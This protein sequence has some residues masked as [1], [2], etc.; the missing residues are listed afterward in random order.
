HARCG[1]RTAGRRP[2]VLSAR[3]RYSRS[4][5]AQHPRARV[6]RRHPRPHALRTSEDARR[7]VRLRRDGEAVVMAAPQT[8][9]PFDVAAIR[10]QF[11]A[12]HQLVH[13]KPLVYLDNA[14]TTQKPQSV[15]D[16]LRRYY[17]HDNA[18]IHRGVHA[19]S[20]RA[21]AMYEQAREDVRAFVNAR[22]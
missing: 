13:G 12:L 2:D 5:S 8:S 9:G 11:P 18:N 15:I 14:A 19:L 22:S 21:S 17:E 7:E 1:D 4:G 3:A 20:E 16:A 10:A 6:C